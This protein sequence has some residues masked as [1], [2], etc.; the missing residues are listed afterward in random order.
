MVKIDGKIIATL[1]LIMCHLGF[2]ILHHSPQMSKELSLRN[3]YDFLGQYFAPRPNVSRAQREAESLGEPQEEQAP[4]AATR[5]QGMN[6]DES[7]ESQESGSEIEEAGP[8]ALHDVYAVPPETGDP[9]AVIAREQEKLCWTLGG[10]LRKTPTPS[11]EFGSAWCSKDA[12]PPKKLELPPVQNGDVSNELMCEVRQRIDQL[13]HLDP[14]IGMSFY[15]W[16]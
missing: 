9:A 11:E 1:F 2:F 5:G 12:T 8:I 4:V 7:Q 16:F 3:L 14:C 15:S 10:E 13:K 6:G